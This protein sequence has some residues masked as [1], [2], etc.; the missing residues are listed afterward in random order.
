MNNIKKQKAGMMKFRLPKAIKSNIEGLLELYRFISIFLTLSIYIFHGIFERYAVP[1]MLILISCVVIYA[2]LFDYL[3]KI[4]FDS[5]K[6]MSLLLIMD[7]TGISLLILLTG[8]LESPFI[9]CFL[10]PLLVIS[11]YLPPRKK[12]PSLAAGIVLL[13]II[14]YFVEGIPEVRQYLLSKSNIILSF[15]LLLILINIL[16]YY[17]NRLIIK[18]RELSLAN[19]DLENYNARIKGMTHDIL[20]MYE[21][22]QSITGLSVQRDIAL[23]LLDFAGRISPESNAFY[24]LDGSEKAESM[25]TLKPLSEAARSSLISVIRSFEKDKHGTAGSSYVISNLLEPGLRVIQTKVSDI[26]NYG[27]IGLIIPEDQYA[28]GKE[29]Y[30]ATLHLMSQLGST[31]FEKAESEE[32]ECELAVADEQNRIADDIHDSI[33]QRLFAASCFAYDTLKKWDNLS[34]DSRKEQL[35]LIME[36]VQDSLRDLRSTIYNLSSKKQNI[37]LFKENIASYLSQMERLSGI[38]ISLDAEGELDS[39]SLNARK[40]IYR[41]ITEC[42]GNAVRHSKCRNIWVTLHMGDEMTK[43]VIKDDGIGLGQQKDGQS[44]NNGL[45]LYNIRSLVRIYNGKLE[46]LSEKDSGTTF[47]IVFRNIDIIKKPED[48]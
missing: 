25:I 45:G 19:Q 41:I 47:N 48:A 46:I 6:R 26:K 13:C 42:T 24:Y 22:V 5:G 21:A 12:Y 9:W 7:I 30:E 35:S 33:M 40:A 16:L 32:I 17:N 27:V 1:M 44:S 10:N 28:K 38:N 34:D 3:Y 36:T 15:T 23:I 20:H 2:F 39:L 14:G 4:S 11:Y 29:E 18:Q 8:G 31:F 37:V 43:L